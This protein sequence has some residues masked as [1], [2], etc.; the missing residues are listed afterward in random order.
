MCFLNW[1]M[2]GI[3]DITAVALYM[4]Y[5]DAFAAVPQWLSALV[6]LAIVTVMNLIGVKWFGEMEFWLTLIKVAALT[7]FLVVGSIMLGG[8][9]TVGGHPT[10][11]YLITETAVFPTMGCWLRWCW[12][13][14][15]Y[16]R[17][18]VSN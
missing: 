3:V 16:S 1:A 11:L 2:A 9:I 12:C 18:P 14:G 15:W 7:L 8:G 5:W 17:M 13:K 6:A 10:G 4:Q